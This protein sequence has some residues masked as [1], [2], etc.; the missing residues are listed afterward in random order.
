MELAAQGRDRSWQSG[1]RNEAWVLGSVCDA[2]GIRAGVKGPVSQGSGDANGCRAL[3][4]ASV[5]ISLSDLLVS[6]RSSIS[7]DG[8]ALCKPPEGSVG[9]GLLLAV[10]VLLKAPCWWPRWG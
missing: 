5:G 7:L 3:A 2:G 10:E 9:P 6:V 1:V 4:H 8:E